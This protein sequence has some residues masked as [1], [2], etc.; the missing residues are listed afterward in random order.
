MPKLL[1]ILLYPLIFIV[2]F[3]VF[4]V[5]LF[6]YDSVKTRVALELEQAMGGIYQIS[7]G[8]LAPNFPN[9]AVLKNVEMKPRSEGTGN[10]IKLNTAKLNFALMPLISGSVQVDFDLKP[11]Q[12]RATG[13]YA[14]KK[15]GLFLN[16]KADRFD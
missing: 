3:L 11:P 8:T 16:I 9:G 10:P 4:V 15:G 14:V 6:P 1:K 12:G 7:I 2:S 13:S 5:L